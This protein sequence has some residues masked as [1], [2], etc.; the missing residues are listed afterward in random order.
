MYHFIGIQHRY[1]TRT[2]IRPKYVMI[3][4][5]CHLISAYII[6]STNGPCI[7]CF[8]HHVCFCDNKHDN[9]MSIPL[10]ELTVNYDTMLSAV[11][12]NERPKVFAE[13]QY[14]H[15]YIYSIFIY[16]IFTNR[17]SFSDNT[18]LISPISEALRE[19]RWDY[20][21]AKLGRY[22]RKLGWHNRFVARDDSR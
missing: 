18:N 8:V 4:K 15:T 5:M 2:H 13:C 21:V 6:D 20:C 10:R 14:I 22:I 19:A 3:I 7:L 11:Y 16:I 9:S 17:M 1:R 12:I